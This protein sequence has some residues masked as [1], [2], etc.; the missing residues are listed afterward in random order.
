MGFEG[1]IRPNP[2]QSANPLNPYAADQA[3]KTANAKKPEIKQPH[4]DEKTTGVYKELPHYDEREE[5]KHQEH[6][7]QEE[8]E[9]VMLFARM[10]GI[11]N[12]SLSEN[13][14]YQFH[15]NPETGMVD[16]IAESNGKV[17]MTLTPDE[18]MSLTD[19]IHRYAGMLADRSG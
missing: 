12:L 9:E 16:L 2:L 18:L 14:L 10:R 8:Y 13:E 15:I 19:K 1:I 4:S 5:R 6:L 17:V 7:S 11:L 3:L